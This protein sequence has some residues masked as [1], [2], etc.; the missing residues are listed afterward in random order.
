MKTLILALCLITLSG[1]AILQSPLFWRLTAKTA[2][3]AAY[4]AG[5]AQA[6]AEKIDEMQDAGKLTQAQAAAIKTAAAEGVQ[7]LEE[8]L[9]KCE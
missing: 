8:A 6:V 5:G 7:R 9:D 1:C 3:R 2:I 4:D